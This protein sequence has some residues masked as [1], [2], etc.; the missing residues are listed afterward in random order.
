MAALVVV[1]TALHALSL[2]A[3]VIRSG[4]QRSSVLRLS[5]LLPEP[6]GASIGAATGAEVEKNAEGIPVY[7]LRTSG[8][9]TRLAADGSGTTAADEGVAFAEGE[10]VSI[11]TTDVIEMVQQQGG[12]AER[13]SC[14]GE[15]IQVDGMTFDDL[16]AED[17]LDISS[18]GE[19]Q[20]PV[21]SLVVVEHRP[22]LTAPQLVQIDDDNKRQSVSRMWASMAAHGFSGWTA[23]VSQPGR[24]HAG[25]KIS[26]RGADDG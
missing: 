12:A 4:L 25:C 7:M 20:G 5:E 19:G 26:K 1:A 14:L 6:P 17:I 15:T 24:I 13:V 3:V 2:R 22:P 21:V 18:E 16:Q 9:V 11:V 23:R 8:T 10:V